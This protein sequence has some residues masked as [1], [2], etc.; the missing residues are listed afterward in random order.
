[1]FDPAHGTNSATTNIHRVIAEHNEVSQKEAKSHADHLILVVAMR[2]ARLNFDPTP[3]LFE[4]RNASYS[5]DSYTKKQRS[6]Y[7]S[8]SFDL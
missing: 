8:L 1:V 2:P 4:D 7:T 5:G 6:R 3:P